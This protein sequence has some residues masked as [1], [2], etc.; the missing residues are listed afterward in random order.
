MRA[1]I[2]FTGGGINREAHL[3]DLLSHPAPVVTIGRHELPFSSVEIDNI[4]GTMDAT[5]HLVELGHRRIAFLSGPLTSATAAD[6]LEGFRRA[7]MQHDL[8]MEERL[9][10]EGD[11]SIEGGAKGLR[12]LLESPRPPTALFAAN[13][14]MAIGAPREARH[15]PLPVPEELAVVGFNDIPAASEAVPPLTTIHLSLRQIGRMA[16]ELLLKQL[17]MGRGARVPSVLTGA[18][19][20]CGNRRYRNRPHPNLRHS[21]TLHPQHHPDRSCH[22]GSLS[23]Q[24]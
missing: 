18:S 1:G 24:E 21:N 10:A 14:E 11:F 12:Q 7:M 23:D 8:P 13:D 2:S 19:R 9:V 15:R 20:W 17:Q 16:A 4:Q 22:G 5:T 3:S 6:R